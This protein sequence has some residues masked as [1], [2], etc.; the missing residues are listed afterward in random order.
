MATG[1]EREQ[2]KRR[3]VRMGPTLQL[4]PEGG[5]NIGMTSEDERGRAGCSRS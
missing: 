5:A 3:V 2:S 1:K 4:G